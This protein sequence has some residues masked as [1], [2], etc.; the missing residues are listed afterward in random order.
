MC[1]RAW[2]KILWLKIHRVLR[3]WKEPFMLH[4][5]RKVITIAGLL[6]SV[7]M[8]VLS[9]K[10]I[11]PLQKTI[12]FHRLMCSQTLREKYTATDKYR[13]YKNNTSNFAWSTIFIR[14][15]K[16]ECES[17]HVQNNKYHESTYHW[18]HCQTINIYYI[19]QF[20]YTVHAKL[21]LVWH[22]NGNFMPNPKLK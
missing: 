22:F 21:K 2:I 10:L 6:S 13:G 19:V 16:M 12:I 3:I 7:H 18:L 15:L 5:F 20:E 11:L 8:H 17:Q 14:Y 1:V 9:R 4:A